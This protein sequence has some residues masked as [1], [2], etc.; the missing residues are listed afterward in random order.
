MI[1]G[2][3]LMHEM[4]IDV[5]IDLQDDDF[6]K[7]STKEIL[8]AWVQWI[9]ARYKVA[10]IPDICYAIIDCE[11]GD[12]VSMI[13]A[14]MPNAKQQANQMCASL[15]NVPPLTEELSNDKKD[16]MLHAK[17]VADAFLDMDDD[18]FMDFLLGHISQEKEE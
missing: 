6:D 16:D 2:K 10:V 3:D 14:D 4:M 12:V 11:N 13:N 15:N 5:F 9:D 7:K 17:D 18:S 1:D 8:L